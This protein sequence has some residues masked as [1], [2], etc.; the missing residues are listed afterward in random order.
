M[1]GH[2]K[3]L[4]LRGPESKVVDI[5]RL[6][7]DTIEGHRDVAAGRLCDLVVGLRLK[8]VAKRRNAKW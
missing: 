6:C 3:L 4:P 5:A 7:N 1:A 2:L 8:H